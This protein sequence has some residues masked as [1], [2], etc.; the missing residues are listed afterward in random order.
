MAFTINEIEN[1]SNTTLDHHMRG[2]PESQSIQEKPLLAALKA[3]QKTFPG[4]KEYI[5]GRVKNDYT[6]TFMGFDTDDTVTYRN[7][8]NIK[9][10][11]YAW[12]ELHAGIQ[13]TLSEL[14]KQGIS[15]V[16]SLDG[17][18]TTQASAAEELILANILDDKLED[19]DEG[20]ARSHN[21]INWG[22]GTASAKI[23]PGILHF[24]AL[25]PTTGVVGGIDRATNTWWRNRAKTAAKFA[26]TGV[27]ADNAIASSAA[28][29][30]LTKTLRA[31]LRQLRRYGGRPDLVLAG[32]GFIEKLENEIHEKGTYTQEGFASTK[33]TDI[34]MS[35]ITMKG[36]GKIVYD[37]T[38][39]DLGLTDYCFFIDTRHLTLMVME[40]EDMKVHNPARPPEK[41]VLYRGITW[42]G[43]MIAKKMN[44]HGVYQAT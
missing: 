37:P 10:F 9:T 14:K 20:T 29:Q 33:A 21:D 32:S 43:T 31:E 6:T 7:P 40:N 25:N 1:I 18:E 38:L 36:V 42:T 39:D 27:A 24:V 5:T 30:T 41:Y 2:Q 15:V 19:L 8:A 16:D 44:C 26:A 35:D 23:Y 22:D 4:G 3:K 13:I 28:N 11:Q 34:T 17:E 12:K